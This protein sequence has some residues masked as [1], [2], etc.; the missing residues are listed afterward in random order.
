ML[1]MQSMGLVEGSFFISHLLKCSRPCSCLMLVLWTN[2]VALQPSVITICLFL[3]PCFFIFLHSSLQQLTGSWWQKVCAIISNLLCFCYV[4][5][6][7]SLLQPMPFFLC[8]TCFPLCVHKNLKIA[9]GHEWNLR[10]G[11][12]YVCCKHILALVIYFDCEC[13]TMYSPSLIRM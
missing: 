9:Y 7:D 2:L 8:C 5:P 3:E 11:E 12:R 13:S 10:M 1:C 6:W 4:L